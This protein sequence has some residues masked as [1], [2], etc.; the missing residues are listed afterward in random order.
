MRNSLTLL[1][2]ASAVG[3][4]ATSQA[5]LF[6]IDQTEFDVQVDY[7]RTI[8]RQTFAVSGYIFLGP[9][10]MFARPMAFELDGAGNLLPH[11]Y[12]R[13]GLA[14]NSDSYF[15]YEGL[16]WFSQY[17]NEVRYSFSSS[18]LSPVVGESRKYRLFA[19]INAWE[20]S[21]DPS[22]YAKDPYVD[23][24]VNF[25]LDAVP[26]PASLAVLGFGAL[27]LLRRKKK[28]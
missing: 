1:A 20:D 4:S 21:E 6:H 22:Y 9:Y 15:N 3:L 12:D 27:A 18:G 23:V 2:V 7:S 28:V 24:T 14:L 8:L 11:D 10:E 13:G 19:G 5:A 16:T 17:R 26:E 25:V